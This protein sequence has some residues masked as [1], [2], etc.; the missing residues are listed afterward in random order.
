MFKDPYFVIMFQLT[1][2]GIVLIG[3]LFLIWKAIS[4]I[5]E[6]VDMLL[7]QKER[8]TLMSRPEA[9]AHD[10]PM[11]MMD[12]DIIMQHLFNSPQPTTNSTHV[13]EMCEAEAEAEGQG[14]A[15]DEGEK[16][17]DADA[18]VEPAPS[19]FSE[20]PMSRSKLRQMPLEKIKALCEERGIAV[21][22]TKNQLIDKLM[23]A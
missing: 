3:G 9:E 13:E 21:D 16:K 23:V 4:R 20:S 10:D 18:E 11:K 8:S 2:I 12:A 1:L 22:G 19:E 14:Q 7:I 17:G 5:E 6:N 15:E